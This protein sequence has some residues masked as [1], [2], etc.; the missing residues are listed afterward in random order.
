M[1]LWKARDLMLLTYS[2][3]VSILVLLDVALEGFSRAK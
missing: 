3:D 1:L 2:H